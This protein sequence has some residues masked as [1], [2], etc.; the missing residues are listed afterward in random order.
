MITKIEI[1]LNVDIHFFTTG[2]CKLAGRANPKNLIFAVACRLLVDRTAPF[3][4]LPEA[5]ARLL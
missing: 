3:L 5:V 2:R 4:P 1:P